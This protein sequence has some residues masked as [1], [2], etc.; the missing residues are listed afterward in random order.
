MNVL[1]VTFRLPGLDEPSYRQLAAEVAPKI[2][3]APG[4]LSKTWLADPTTSTYG[5]LVLFDSQQALDAYLASEVIRELRTNPRLTEFSAARFDPLADAGR[6]TKGLL[7]LAPGSTMPRPATA[8]GSSAPCRRLVWRTHQAPS[9]PAA[10]PTGG[11]E[12]AEWR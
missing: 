11:W 7:P 5:G 6:L 8:R 12:D 3:Q 10:D 1:L 4:L 2:A 9:V